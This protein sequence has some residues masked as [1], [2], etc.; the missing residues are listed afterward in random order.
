VV[1]VIVDGAGLDRPGW[2]ERA[3]AQV[4]K[5]VKN[6]AQGLKIFKNLGMTVKDSAG[7]RVP[8]DDPRIDPVWAKCAELGIPVLIH[9]AEPASF[10]QPQ[11]RFNERWLELKQLTRRA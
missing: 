7:K 3:A 1:C 11:D 9:T 6:G 5:D 2:G 8:T 10:F 4:E